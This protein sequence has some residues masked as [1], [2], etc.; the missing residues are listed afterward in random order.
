VLVTVSDK[1]VGINDGTYNGAGIKLNNTL[2]NFSD[3]FVAE[4]VTA[5]DYYPG[6]MLMPGRK[7]SVGSAYRYGFNGQEKVNEISGEGNHNTAKFGELD[8]RLGRRWNL[9]PKPNPSTSN[10]SVF[11][12]CPIWISDIAL[13]TPYS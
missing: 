1:R 9:D 12:N 6:G 11:N 7:Y 3:Y 10:Y 8:T 4:V 5:N 13:D 2:D